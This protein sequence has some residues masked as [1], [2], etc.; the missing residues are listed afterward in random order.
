MWSHAGV[1]AL[2]HSACLCHLRAVTP[3]HRAVG[4]LCLRSSLPNCWLQQGLVSTWLPAQAFAQAPRQAVQSSWI[5]A[6]S[7]KVHPCHLPSQAPLEVTYTCQG[8]MTGG[9]MTRQIL[10]TEGKGFAR[11][12]LGVLYAA[13]K[14]LVRW[15]KRAGAG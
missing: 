14:Q 3:A 4:E 10:K 1:P 6:W 15:T 12:C 2:A 5:R 8:S 13:I 9:S 7:F 11:T